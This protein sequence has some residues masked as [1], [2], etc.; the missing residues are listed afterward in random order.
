VFAS[1]SFFL[2]GTTVV[3]EDVIAYIAAIVSVSLLFISS[4]KVPLPIVVKNP[5]KKTA[6][7]ILNKNPEMEDMISFVL[8]NYISNKTKF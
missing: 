6:K 5:C 3:I 2:N 1:V 7:G 8:K 4:K